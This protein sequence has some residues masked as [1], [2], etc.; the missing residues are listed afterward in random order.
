[1]REFVAGGT[2]SLHFLPT[3][4]AFGAFIHFS[5]S[6]LAA[7]MAGTFGTGHITHTDPTRFLAHITVLIS[8]GFWHLASPSS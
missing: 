7:I 1:M 3:F 6:M 2:G 4:K 8:F 5:I